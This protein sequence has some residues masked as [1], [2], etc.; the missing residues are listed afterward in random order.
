MSE[1]TTL[2]KKLEDR[3]WSFGRGDALDI[4]TAAELRRLDAV[5]AELLEVLI[6]IMSWEENDRMTWSPKVRAAIAKAEGE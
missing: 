2:A 3:A 5:N 4:S 6:E 1:A